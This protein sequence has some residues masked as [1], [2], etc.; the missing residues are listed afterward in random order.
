MRAMTRRGAFLAELHRGVLDKRHSLDRAE[1][2][3]GRDAGAHIRVDD[4]SVSLRD[5]FVG[6]LGTGGA[7]F[8]QAR[9]GEQVVGDALKRRDD[10]DDAVFAG[11]INDQTRGSC[12]ISHSA[13]SCGVSIGSSRTRAPSSVT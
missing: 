4:G 8:R 6:L 12:A 9:A 1:T 13:S 7:A 3:I 11:G 2:I 10:H 5:L